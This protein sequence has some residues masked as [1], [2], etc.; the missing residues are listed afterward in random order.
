MLEILPEF[1]KLHFIQ[2]WA[3]NTPEQVNQFFLI[4]YEAKSLEVNI[5]KKCLY[6]KCAIESFL[7]CFIEIILDS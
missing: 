6:C 7:S 4:Y 5:I 3:I 2:V 1:G